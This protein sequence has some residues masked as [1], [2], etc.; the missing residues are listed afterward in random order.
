MEFPK[1]TENLSI[2]STLGDNPGV[3]NGLTAEGLKAKFDEA[4][5]IL[6][7]YINEKLVE[8]L[9]EIFAGGPAAPS[10]GFNMNGPINMNR[11]PIWNVRDPVGDGDALNLQFAN[12][13]YVPKARTINDKSLADNLN[14]SA[15]DVG[16]RSDTWLPTLAEIGAAPIS[17]WRGTFTGN[18]DSTGLNGL[19]W[20]SSG[21]TG[22][23][24]DDMPQYAFLD[25]SS[26]HQRLM[27]FGNSGITKIYERYYTNNKWYDWHRTDSVPND[28]FY[29]I[30]YKTQEKWNGKDVWAKVINLGTMQANGLKNHS[31]GVKKSEN[32]TFISHE[33]SVTDGTFIYNINSRSFTQGYAYMWV[34][35][36]SNAAYW[37]VNVVA[38]AS[39]NSY[40][41]TAIV[42]WIYN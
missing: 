37:Q 16:A 9:N 38:E 26:R 4:A 2:I 15:K 18:I 40:T 17:N 42:K 30:A 7:R 25:A 24:P 8:G 1:L 34:D 20:L 10:D 27:Y 32:V 12:A 14:L 23:V 19:Y 3:D 13:T 22:T 5:L 31:T 6:Q 29:G 21:H 39:M 35:P 41:G 11:Q 36:N 28:M 33:V